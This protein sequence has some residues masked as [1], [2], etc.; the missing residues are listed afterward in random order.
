MCRVSQ[1]CNGDI[2]GSLQSD[3][4]DQTNDRNEYAYLKDIFTEI[5]QSV[6]RKRLRITVALD[7]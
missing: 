3:Q 6:N 2:W 7:R 1:F 4:I 5:T